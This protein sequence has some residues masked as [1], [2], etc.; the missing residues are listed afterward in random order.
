MRAKPSKGRSALLLLSLAMVLG[1]VVTP[2]PRLAQASEAATIGS[3]AY[4]AT[5]A[6]VI[7]LVSIN[8]PGFEKTI[9]YQF[10]S[11]PSTSWTTP[12]FTDL[13]LDGD[14]GKGHVVGRNFD[15]T[16]VLTN[17][18]SS[19]GGVDV[20]LTFYDQAGA[21][22]NGNPITVHI[23]PKGTQVRLASNLLNS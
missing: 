8:N 1:M 3:I 6:S 19:L 2:M 9:V 16:I 13:E 23:D 18:S 10:P 11:P 4:T 17:T 21:A 12:F 20:S 14:G 15:T 22:I 7:G 5:E